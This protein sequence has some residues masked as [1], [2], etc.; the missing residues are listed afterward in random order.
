M[1]PNTDSDSFPL[2]STDPH[3]LIPDGDWIDAPGGIAGGSGGSGGEFPGQ[4]S[5]SGSGSGRVRARVRARAVA[6]VRARVRARA[7]RAT[8]ARARTPITTASS[9]SSAP[10]KALRQCIGGHRPPYSFFLII[11]L[12]RYTL[13]PF[14]EHFL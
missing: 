8:R 10:G 3:P 6:R 2:D 12:F 7:T 5:G 1:N 14:Q 11:Y 13:L 4:G 9:T